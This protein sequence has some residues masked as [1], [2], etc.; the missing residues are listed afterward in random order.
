M[1]GSDGNVN[2]LK[3]TKKW[4]SSGRKFKKVDRTT[5]ILA[6]ICPIFIRRLR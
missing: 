3:S 4:F 2:E 5:G 1:G 6:S